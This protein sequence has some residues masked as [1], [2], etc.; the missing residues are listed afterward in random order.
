M[1]PIELPFGGQS[2]FR[3]RPRKQQG[4]GRALHPA[5]ERLRGARPTIEARLTDR[6]P[7]A[8]ASTL[9]LRFHHRRRRLGRLRARRPADRADGRA[10]RARAGIRRLGPLGPH[11]D[12]ERPVHPDEHGRSTIGAMRPSRSRISAAGAC[13]CPRGKVLG[14]S[15]SINGLVYVRGN[16]LDFERWEEEGARAGATATC[17]PISGA[18]STP[19]GGRR[20]LSRRRRAARD[21]LRPRCSNPLYRAF[22]EAA[23]QAGYPATGRHQRL[24]AGRLRPHGHDRP[25]RPPLVAPPTPISSRR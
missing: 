20:R 24:P 7:A 13:T 3:P 2:S 8:R 16:P 9:R 1:T 14:G 25:G 12:A 11:P 10:T 6:S 22:I 19:A 5:Q 15:S 4:G 17:C 23:R 18:P 21:P